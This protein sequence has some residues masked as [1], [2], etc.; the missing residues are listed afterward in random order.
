MVK[1]LNEIKNIEECKVA[2]VTIAIDTNEEN[3]G[4]L[5]MLP[6]DKLYPHPDNPRKSLGNLTELSESIKAKGVMQNLT[7]VPRAER[8]GTYTIIIGHR[9]HAA[10]KKAKLK[11]LPCVIV[12]M[13][14]QEQVATMLL[15]NI[16]RSDLTAYEQAKG[17]QMM[18]D[19]GDSVKGIV[20]KTGFSES[21]VR[22]R[23]KM[24][25][26]DDEV[27]KKVS[28]RQISFGDIDKLQE[29]E[30][31]QTRNKVLADIGTANFNN[32][33]RTA[34][35]NQKRAAVLKK[36]RDAFE[37]A[38]LKEVTWDEYND[39][40]N[41]DKS[42]SIPDEV[43]ENARLAAERGATAYYF[44]YNTTFYTLIKKDV[45]KNTQKSAEQI[46]REKAE[47]ERR[48][49]HAKLEEAFE[50]VYALRREF[51]DKYPMAQALKN[52]VKIAAFLACMGMND[53]TRDSLCKEDFEKITFGRECELSSYEETCDMLDT[54]ADGAKA[55][56][57][58]VWLLTDD[59]GLDC[60]DWQGYYEENED[61]NMI[62][63]FL[64]SLGYE[65]SDEERELLDGTSE[66]Y[67]KE[68]E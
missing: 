5:V 38:G 64:E 66:L 23:L 52:I 44:S 13:S 47:Q 19:F 55:M 9:R 12:E 32:S 54:P 31:L 21:T 16:Q 57:V 27:L 6:I 25:E 49:R 3:T 33:F 30:D 14:E 24:A 4:A 48:E 58:A 22:R 20:D 65:M 60:Y 51:I 8:D 7:V 10:A 41:Y 36:M 15:E 28:S 61:L 29:I 46:A 68:V 56:L 50:R 1:D 43:E 37:A 35:A 67:E 40:Y 45:T 62:Y 42:I 2:P 39:H 11:E 59:R 63:E 53:A 17:F 18:M 34:V 26:L